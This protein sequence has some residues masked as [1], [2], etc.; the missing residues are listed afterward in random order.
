MR[1]ILIAFFIMITIGT[2]GITQECFASDL[3]I[4]AQGPDGSYFKGFDVHVYQRDRY[5]SYAGHARAGTYL[6][7]AT[8]KG[9][10]S[11]V[12][13]NVIVCIEK[14][15]GYITGGYNT[16]I[17]NGSRTITIPIKDLTPYGQCGR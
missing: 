14:G 3:H 4:Y 9:L 10:Q 2:I 5:Y 6:K 13:Y 11:G 12:G 16:I 17:R 8:V 7:Y 15:R 1:R